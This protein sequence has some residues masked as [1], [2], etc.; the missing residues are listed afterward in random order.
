MLLQ[1]YVEKN[2]REKNDIT[3]KTYY[4]FIDAN[5]GMHTFIDTLRHLILEML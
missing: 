1:Y 4:D 5:R 3:K 2:G